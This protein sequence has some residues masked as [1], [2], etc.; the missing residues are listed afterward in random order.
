MTKKGFL[1]ELNQHRIG[2]TF[3]RFFSMGLLLYLAART[4]PDSFSITLV[5]IFLLIDELMLWAGKLTGHTAAALAVTAAMTALVVLALGKPRHY[6]LLAALAV[7]AAM[8]FVQR[9]ALL[10]RVMLAALAAGIAAVPAS[11]LPRAAAAG[12]LTL[13]LM[14]LETVFH[15]GQSMRYYLLF[16]LMELAVLWV[17]G[18]QQRFDWSFIYRIGDRMA[19]VAESFMMNAEYLFSELGITGQYAGGYSGLGKVG[20]GISG[21]GR[22]EVI[23]DRKPKRER[24]YLTGSAFLTRER[25]GWTDRA[26]S[27]DIVNGW[28][29]DFLNALIQQDIPVEE[30][31]CFVEMRENSV[32]FGYLRTKDLLHPAALLTLDGVEDSLT[33]DRGSFL[34]SSSRGRRFRYSFRYAAF[35]FANPYL[36]KVLRNAPEHTR[37]YAEYEELEAYSRQLFSSWSFGTAVSGEDYRKHLEYLGKSAPQPPGW[38]EVTR[39]SS[40]VRALAEEITED[41]DTDFDRC[42]A[43]EAYLRQYAYDPAADYQDSSDYVESFLFEE[44]RGY[45]VHYAAA[46]T[47]LLRAVGIPA[48]YCEG[49]D[50]GSGRPESEGTNFIL[51]GSAAHAWPE[52]YIAGYGWVAFEPCAV[53]Y[54]TG[55]PAF[56]WGHLVREETGAPAGSMPAGYGESAMPA[57]PEA[58]LPIQEETVPEPEPLLTRILPYVKTAGIITASLAAAAA[59]LIALALSARKIRYRRKDSAGRLGMLMEDIRALT[60]KVCPGQDWVNRP[61]AFYE[62][63][64]SSPE[65]PVD[66]AAVRTVFASYYRSRFAGRPPEDTVLKRAGMIRKQLIGSLPAPRALMCLMRGGFGQMH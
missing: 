11:E 24:L 25:D 26:R 17:P 8:C 18:E 62:A 37:G 51:R 4:F 49:Y 29:L 54:G 32:T 57:V 33:A 9:F 53:K 42:M 58:A 7:F 55:A 41:M 12:L 45:C 35:D 1:S 31:K 48:R 16:A 22:I 10:R 19:G 46:M 27:D 6:E 61:A 50:A 44:K 28:Y 2:G 40:R 60:E 59:A 30:A 63:A 5:L 13:V 15:R 21:E 34:L 3:Y 43:V 23:L 66:K 39:I 14:E 38:D 47:E 52:A 56:A 64:L 65:V 20:G 36:V